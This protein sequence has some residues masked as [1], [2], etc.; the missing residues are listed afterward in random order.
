MEEIKEKSAKKPV[1][2]RLTATASERLMH[3]IELYK[4][5]EDPKGEQQE[6][7]ILRILDIAESDNVR[8]THP[9]LEGPLLAVEATIS[10]LIKQLNGIAVGQDAKISRLQEALRLQRKNRLLKRPKLIWI[11]PSKILIW[12]TGSKKRPWIR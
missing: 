12:L 3:I 8:G 4:N 1:S 2:M 7:A 9:E 6:N 11:R 10:A 5:L